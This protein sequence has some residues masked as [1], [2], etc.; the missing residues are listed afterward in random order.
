MVQWL[1]LQAS[2]AK[3]VGLILGQGIKIPHGQIYIKKKKRLITVL[4]VH[5]NVREKKRKTLNLGPETVS[6]CP[7]HALA[8]FLALSA[9]PNSWA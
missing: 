7:V 8:V 2:N 6:L 1:G 3:S 9:F 4:M 5:A